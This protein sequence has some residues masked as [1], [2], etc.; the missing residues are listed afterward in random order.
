MRKC[1]VLVIGAGPSGCVSAAIAHKNDLEVIVVEKEKFPRF[2]IGESLLPRCMEALQE[3]DF[4]DVLQ[5]QGFQPKFGA[6]FV[7]GDTICDFNFI[8]QF[9]SGW[10]WTWQVPRA[11]FDLVLANEIAK[12][13]VPVDFEKAVRNIEF[14]ED[15]SITEL[16]DKDGNVEFI[17]AKF[18]ID[19]SGYGRVIPK[20][21]NLDKPSDQPL[22]TTY[23]SHFTDSK[24]LDF[25]EP[26]RITII[27]VR[28][29]V[30]GWMIPFA[31]GR[32]S[33][34]I[35]G[36]PDHF[37]PFE[38]PGHSTG[39]VLKSLIQADKYIASRFGDQEFRL[40]PRKLEG[41][42]V[43]TQKFYGSGF[44]LTGNVTEFLDPMFS[45]GVTLAVVSGARAA[46]LVVKKLRGI[47]VDWEEEYMKPTMVGVDVFRTFVKA[48]Y[49]GTLPTIFF[50]QNLD[51]HFKKQICSVLAG[52]VWDETNPFVTK[53][54]KALRNLAEFIRLQ[55][56]SQA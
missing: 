21:L 26:N 17:E 46:N 40:E 55:E 8:D 4:F 16:V 56:A 38:L 22:R 35:V 12:R 1:D 19:S 37:R 30:W 18:I 24:R 14:R 20:L 25:E 53:R 43:T 15:H 23:F 28:P 52:Y 39:D 9:T 31:D 42:S 6:K 3:A 10:S 33:V 45:S 34:G 48:W 50:G 2:V 41:W 47:P 54:D 27:S 32:T 7:R 44:V 51:Q 13:G 11:E 29:G 5:E 36:H 49:D